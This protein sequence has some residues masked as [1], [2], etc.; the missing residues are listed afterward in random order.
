MNAWCLRCQDIN[1]SSVE[2]HKRHLYSFVHDLTVELACLESAPGS[3]P[4]SLVLKQRSK[5]EK[6]KLVLKYSYK[7]KNTLR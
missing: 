7:K 4:L 5:V 1:V 2:P 6:A 3:V